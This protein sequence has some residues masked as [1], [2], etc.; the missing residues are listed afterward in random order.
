[1]HFE[2]TIPAPF[3]F[4]LAK[5]TYYNFKIAPWCIPWVTPSTVPTAMDKP[6]ERIEL[7]FQVYKTRFLYH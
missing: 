4:N 5:G 1:M 3:A 6:V 2:L 7:S